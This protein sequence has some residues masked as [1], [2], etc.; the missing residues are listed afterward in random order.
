MALSLAVNP[1]KRAGAPR[2]GGVALVIPAALAF[3]LCAAAAQAALYKWVDA[4][5]TVVYS[6]QPPPGGIKSEIVTAPVAPPSNPNAVK[7]MAN[8]DLEQKKRLAQQ[9]QD[10]KAADKARVDENRKREACSQMRS[11]LR[12][13][14]SGDPL[15][16]ID[17]N[18]KRVDMDD[19][20]KAKERERLEGEIRER[21][22]S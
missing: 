3:L 16:R 13:L 2:R 10:E 17:E 6:D 1:L 20:A 8:R 14:Q 5:G 15:Y 19:A 18:G 21:C 22:M 7:D 11:G 12:V 9:A 4:S